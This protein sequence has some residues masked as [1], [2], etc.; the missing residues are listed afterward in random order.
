MITT[1]MNLP[2]KDIYDIT[3][4]LVDRIHK[5]RDI[6][7]S[8]EMTVAMLYAEIQLNQEVLGATKAL[9]KDPEAFWHEAVMMLST[10]ALEL[11]LFQKESKAIVRKYFSDCEVEVG[12]SREQ[13]SGTAAA[14]F[15]YRKITALKHVAAILQKAP[16]LRSRY[17]LGERIK[18]IETQMQAI[19]R[20]LR[21]KLEAYLRR[22]KRPKKS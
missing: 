14:F 15:I 12:S 18:N 13:I 16:K 5:A 6:R 19:N 9:L 11:A 2:I 1:T 10:E 21:E 17:K 22:K 7:I 4:D 8:E 20:Q 3:W